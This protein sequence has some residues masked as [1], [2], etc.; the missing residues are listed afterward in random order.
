MSLGPNRCWHGGLSSLADHVTPGSACLLGGSAR[1][2][3]PL[4]QRHGGRS[5]SLGVFHRQVFS[6]CGRACDP[7][8]ALPRDERGGGGNRSQWPDTKW[9]SAD[10]E[11]VSRLHFD[12]PVALKSYIPPLFYFADLPCNSNFLILSQMSCLTISSGNQP[13]EVPQPWLSSRRT[14][15]TFLISSVR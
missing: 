5:V 7:V 3:C 1:E 9:Y 2:G 10:T 8:E 6:S 15:A 11:L 12:V 4:W 13:F 14:W